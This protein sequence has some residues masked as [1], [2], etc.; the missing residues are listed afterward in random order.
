MP[1]D[2]LWKPGQCPPSA[3][4]IRNL[5]ENDPEAY[6]EHLAQRK[7]RKS[8]KQAMKATVEEQQEKWIAMFN[9]AAA[10]LMQQAMDNGDTQAFIAVYDRFI[11][12]PDTSVDVTS[13]GKELA[14][15]TIIFNSVTN[16]DWDDESSDE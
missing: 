6:K 10:K 14:A 8:M 9:N 13:N 2:H 12:K 4:Y 16:T 15:P 5:K 11:G 7:A 1:K 3:L